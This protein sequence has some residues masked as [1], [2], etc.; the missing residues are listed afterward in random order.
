MSNYGN[1]GDA[2]LFSAFAEHYDR[3]INWESRL[4]REIPFYKKIFTDAGAGK[5]LDTACGTG[6]HGILFSSWG[7]EVH[8]V[9]S[10]GEMISKAKE[11]AK[12]A[13]VNVSFRK[14]SIEELDKEFSAGFDVVTC[15]GNSLPHIRTSG[16]L[17]KVFTAVANVLKPGGIF[18]LQIRNYR[19]VLEKNEKYMPLN[20]FADKGKE[21]IYL[22]ITEPGE[23]M[24]TFSILVFQKDEYGK[25]SFDVNSERLKPWLDK[26]I[27]TILIE[28]GFVTTGVYGDL[29]FSSFVPLESTDLVI[30]AQKTGL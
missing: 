13:G 26:D 30:I 1:T 2:N 5:I 8:A 9:D 14:V 4:Q 25:W 15:M 10:S 28:S 16:E 22:R 27:L 6:R 18:T 29:S 21:Y 7:M 12:N 24:V 23:D 11:N 20:S 19:R 3:M 17:R